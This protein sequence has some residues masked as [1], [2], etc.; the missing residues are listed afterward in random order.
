M[1]APMERPAPDVLPVAIR[2]Y[3][4][5]T[6]RSQRRGSRSRA[7]GW[8][9]DVLIFDTE[10][11]VDE[12]QLLTFGSWRQCRWTA[13]GELECVSEGLFFD[14]SL[15][16]TDPK[17]FALLESYAR[18][19]RANVIQGSSTV[20]AFMSKT[21]FV[22]DVFYPLAY[23]ARA[24]VVGFNLPFD[25]TRLA[26]RWGKGRK[27]HFGW[28][29]MILRQYVST[30]T[31]AMAEDAWSSRI[32]IKV[33]DSK[34]AF[35][36]FTSARADDDDGG[37]GKWKARYRGRFLD[38]RTLAYALTAEAYTLERACH[39]FEIRHK[40]G[41]TL[42][43][44]VITDRYIDYNRR[45]VLATQELLEV[46]RRRF[47]ARELKLDPC[48]A[49]SPASVAKAYLR[50][51][52]VARPAKQFAALDRALYGIAMNGYHGGR[53]ECHIRITGVPVVHTDFISQYPT[54]SVLLGLWNLIT[55][56]R[57]TTVD[58]T[59]EAQRLLNHA[60]VEKY[61]D[62]NGWRDLVWFGQLT[63]DGDVLPVRSTYHQHNETMAIGL[64][65]Y[66]S[67][68]PVY[69]AA[70][71][72]IASA[73]LTGRPPRLLRAQKV[74]PHGRQRGL[75]CL[76]FA[77]GVSIDPTTQDFFKSVI[78]LR[79]RVAADPSLSPEQREAASLA[80]KILA[81]AGCYGVF[82]EMNTLSLPKGE[83][84]S[85]QVYSHSKPFDT[86]V[87][88]P[89]EPGEYVFPVVAVLVT[90]GGRLLLA[91]LERLVLDAGGTFAFCDTDSMS[92]V[93]MRTGGN[94]SCDDGI[95]P[96]IGGRKTVRAL[97]W[98]QVETIVARF[99]SLNPYDRAIV[100]GS[101]L[102]VK[103]VNRDARGVQRHLWCYVI[104][105]KRYTFFV[106]RG[107]T[108]SIV[109]P[110]EHGLGHLLDPERGSETWRDELDAGEPREWIRRVWE[111]IIKQSLGLPTGPLPYRDLPAVGRIS[112]STPHVLKPFGTAQK[113]LAYSER[114][115]PMNF[116]LSASIAPFGEP[117]RTSKAKL[118]LIRS[119]TDQ[120]SRW[121]SEPWIDLYSGE[122]YDVTVENPA[123]A[124]VAR[125]RSYGNVLEEFMAH[126][127][128]KSAD[129]R[130]KP[131]GALT[132]GLLYRRRI[133]RER[134]V[135]IGK[136]ANR[137]EDMH[138]RLIH[139]WDEVNTEYRDPD[140]E[141]WNL[142]VLRLLKPISG[143][144]LASAAGVS[145]RAIR[146]IRNG[147]ARPSFETRRRLLAVLHLGARKETAVP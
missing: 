114:V 21:E 55:A 99:A 141:R 115:R 65:E 16:V 82:V 124:H 146:A 112:V 61:L 102:E 134:T 120:P 34:R 54:V 41:K 132:R 73:I 68:E 77:D 136:E 91:L 128:H 81:N 62:P 48:K 1:T 107:R 39:A 89:E 145:T 84:K 72:L 17:G 127:E 20:L 64:N 69:F 38:L 12:R 23:D 67:D 25:L 142:E 92:I 97:S 5:L 24:L 76:E 135:M 100:P 86:A 118:H 94:V 37:A 83:R 104:S 130:G 75:R 98:A 126:P 44:G 47:D 60:S 125:I 66:W 137:I 29:S 43:H 2:V 31:G 14:D 121:L 113:D 46:L 32:A 58:C 108:I 53:A 88:R 63:P 116:L 51:L 147:H 35:M 143:K 140:P 80:L 11:T 96:A 36:E 105:A 111:H 119:F 6:G 85:V 103:S 42:S 40:K 56:K 106:K 144:V 26:E 133:R 8:P 109:E 30:K 4:D 3:A 50:K 57:L 9:A 74:I 49:Y 110:S 27:Q 19:R 131:C 18:H 93:A 28:F 70:P 95:D 90:A 129:A 101:I 10:T 13:A 122:R 59:E 45:D 33:L 87:A 7:A 79:K 15:P 71:D 138:N 78:E 123:P 22:R 52:G 117:A 139:R